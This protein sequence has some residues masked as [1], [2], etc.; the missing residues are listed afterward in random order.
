[1]FIVAT[2]TVCVLLTAVDAYDNGRFRLPYMGWSTWCTDS[3]PVPCLSD[4]CDEQEVRAVATSM[5]KNGLTQL[6]YTMVLLDDCWAATTRSA[7]GE[8]QADTTRF[9]SG[10]L[11]PLA[12]FLH[13]INMTLGAYTDVGPKTCRGGRL[14]SWP[15]YQQDAMTFAKWGLDFVKADYCNHPGG[16]SQ[17]Q[18]YSNFSNALNATGHAFGF[19]ICGWGLSNVWTWGG[20]VSTSFRI[21]PDH[22]PVVYTP[23]N[24]SQDPGQGQ[25]LFNIIHHVTQIS[26]SKHVGP[27]AFADPDFLEPG[28]SWNGAELD[29]VEFSF[30]CL[31]AAPLMVATDVR[32]LSNKAA[33]QNVE[34]IAVNQDPLVIA[35]DIVSDPAS[36][37]QVWTKRLV[38]NRWAVILFN[39]DLLWGSQTPTVSFDG[40]HLDGWPSG[41]NSAAV[42]DIWAHKDLGVFANSY[43]AK[44]NARGIQMLIVTPH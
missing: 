34:A 44:L 30:W 21:G 6:G 43:G 13:S 20:A 2:T 8:I 14:G 15:L 18:L 25:G 41:R 1:M 28:Y 19:N 26:I 36:N 38:N 39:A 5:V 22:L 31:W 16:M 12:D 40:A 10:T 17:Q 32:D 33:I 23:F 11:K 7:S 42:R 24:T 35:G 29:R 9:P 37:S 27:Y 3:G 4:M